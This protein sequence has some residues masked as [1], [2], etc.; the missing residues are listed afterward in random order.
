MV[1]VI[2]GIILSFVLLATGNLGKDRQLKNFANHISHVI[3]LLQQQAILFPAT[4]GIEVTSDKI[5]YYRYKTDKAG[6]LR[7]QTMRDH[8]LLALNQMKGLSL[9]VSVKN[10]SQIQ[11]GSGPHPE[12]IIFPSGDM[13]AFTLSFALKSQAPTWQLSAKSNGEL[14]LEAITQ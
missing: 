2:I 7:W 4:I 12:I 6:K 11:I 10:N 14:E 9:S 13:T 8:A 3:P 1:L 5:N